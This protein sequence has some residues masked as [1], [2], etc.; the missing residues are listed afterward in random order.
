MFA[1]TQRSPGLTLA[2]S[3]RFGGVS[4]GEFAELNLGPHVGDA[5]D[6]VDANRV[7][8]AQG[9]GLARP[10]LAFM[11]QVHGRA[12]A[13]VTAE[14]TLNEPIADALVTTASGIGLAVM[15]ADCLP[16]LLADEGAGVIAVA[17]VGRAGLVAG[18]VGATLSAMRDLGAK[19]IVATVGPSICLS[20]YEVPAALHAEVTRMVP[21]AGGVSAAGTPGLDIA[22]GVTAQ[23]RHDA[24]LIRRDPR[25]PRESPDLFSFRRDG[26]TGR[27]AGIIVRHSE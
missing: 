19:E 7:R 23:L 6:A 21:Q 18:V 9:L 20:C 1:W 11:R 16:L 5:V 26:S 15:V 12:V 2:V 8:L 3:D 14:N 25:C 22:A 24:K 27:F 10:Q 13:E 17:H 4:A